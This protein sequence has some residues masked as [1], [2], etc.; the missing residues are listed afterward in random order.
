[1]ST[2]AFRNLYFAV[3]VIV[4]SSGV[5]L[6]V[7]AGVAGPAVEQAQAYRD[8]SQSVIALQ[9]S[10][11][12][13]L[14]SESA[15]TGTTS[16]GGAE[17]LTSRLAAA[18]DGASLHSGY[19]FQLIDSEGRIVSGT[20][21]ATDAVRNREPGSGANP[22]ST[23]AI[24]TNQESPSAIRNRAEVAS[25]LRGENGYDVRTNPSG[26]LRSYFAA[27]LRDGNDRFALRGSA[28]FLRATAPISD[29]VLQFSLLAGS[30]I[31]ISTLLVTILVRRVEQ[32]FAVIYA[33]GRTLATGNL[34]Y[35][36]TVDLPRGVDS[37]AHLVNRAIDQLR[38][39][40]AEVERERDDVRTTLSAMV[41]GVILLD[42]RLRVRTMNRSAAALFGTTPE[43]VDGS[44]LLE[45]LRN[46]ELMDIA[47]RAKNSAQT[48]ERTISV[49]RNTVRRLQVHATSLR[50]HDAK[51]EGVLIVLNDITR[52][53]HLEELRKEFV[54]NVSHELRTP[55][56]SIKGFVETLLD[57]ANENPD[58]AKRF[59]RIILNHTNRIH[60]I[61]EDLLSLSRLEQRDGAL[62]FE[63]LNIETVV[64]ATRDLCAGKAAEKG[65]KIEIR[66]AGP[67]TV[68]GNPR[69]LEQA[70]TNLLDNAVKYSG[71]GTSVGIDVRNLPGLLT[72]SV[73]D[74]GIG[75]PA[76]DLPRVFERFYRV[77]RARSRD[78]GGT[79]L[80]LAIVK[81]IALAHGGEVHVESEPGKGSV[82]TMY[83]PQR[84][85]VPP[86]NLAQ[87]DL[88]DD[89]L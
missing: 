4:I 8:I 3:T 32:G 72:I 82:F 51:S 27:P 46:T 13:L 15:A 52:L 45:S 7:F 48:V 34:E 41:E 38:K 59:L 58:Q 11:A 47:E 16:S 71:N 66:Y 56:T 73:R 30:L 14:S 69:L 31:V 36:V 62:D 65:M 68:R 55:I 35:R 86:E 9:P 75:I 6:V 83:L 2:G 42:A 77:D 33:A 67:R 28:D 44:T 20:D 50:A 74:A 24:T 60:L 70:L 87:E 49:Y 53:K 5:L 79:G 10:I 76:K 78:V 21:S 43:A 54:S 19:D 88:D 18:L 29:F 89:I 61:I 81:H 25:A 39:R 37:L 17:P 40:I 22:A 64:T 1:M 85:A 57:G 23:S 63:E 12:A 80:G 26:A 84:V